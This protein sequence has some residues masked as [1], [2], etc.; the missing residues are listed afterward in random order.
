MQ[1]IPVS[2]T[3]FSATLYSV[4]RGPLEIILIW[5]FAVQETFNII[6]IIIIIIINI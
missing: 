4:S 2:Q 1:F 6:I 5:W 3:T